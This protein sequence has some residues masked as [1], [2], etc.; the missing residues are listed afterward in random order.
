MVRRTLRLKNDADLS[1]R[2]SGALQTHICE[3][4]L[5]AQKHFV[6][7]VTLYCPVPHCVARQITFLVAA[8]RQEYTSLMSRAPSA[9]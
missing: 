3:P 6:L 9:R 5:R 7:R 2:G 4:Q 1:V 8:F